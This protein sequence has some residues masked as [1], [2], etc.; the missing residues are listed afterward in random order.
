[1]YYLRI[2]LLG[3]G[4]TIELRKTPIEVLTAPPHPVVRSVTPSLIPQGAAPVRIRYAG[5]EN[6]GGTVRIYRTDLPS[7]PRL[8]KSFPTPWNGETAT[9]DGTILGRPAPAGTYLVGLDVTD[10][11][12]N[13]GHFPPELPPVAGSTRG[14]GW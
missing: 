12:C 7:G 8:V 6:R 13:T 3:Q 14:R 4:R 10:K 11:A 2:A 1:I 9:W 5:N